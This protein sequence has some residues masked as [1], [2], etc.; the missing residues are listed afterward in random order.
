VEAGKLSGFGA[1][2][3][4]PK[5]ESGQEKP[6]DS[7]PTEARMVSPKKGDIF[8]QVASC[9]EANRLVSLCKKQNF[10]P[11]KDS[12]A[13]YGGHADDLPTAGADSR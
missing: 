10:Q 12:F 6:V 7:Q 1:A 11:P 4:A 2:L 5:K 13:A 9:E 8:D 3:A